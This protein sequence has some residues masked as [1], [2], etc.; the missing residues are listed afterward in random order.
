MKL[1]DFLGNEIRKGDIVTLKADHIVGQI[2]E[3]DSGEIARGLSLEGSPRGEIRPPI[4][5]IQV[6]LQMVQVGGLDGKFNSVV[7]VVKPPT[8]E[9][10]K[11]VQ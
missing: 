9:D 7:K 6:N 2:I 3:I 1:V 5:A 8:Q 4:V 11:L 10:H